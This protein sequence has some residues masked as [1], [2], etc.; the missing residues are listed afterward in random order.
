[1]CCCLS[2]IWHTVFIYITYLTFGFA[3]LVLA[4][5]ARVSQKGH[6]LTTHEKLLP[7]DKSWHLHL[8]QLITVLM[9]VMRECNESVMRV[10]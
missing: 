1:M 3:T 5:L 7:V 8:K 9:S 6:I 4:L 2:Q 10:Y